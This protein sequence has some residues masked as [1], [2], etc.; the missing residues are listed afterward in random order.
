MTHIKRWGLFFL[1]SGLLGLFLYFRLYRYLSFENLK[2]HRMILINWAHQHFFQAIS[3]FMAIYTLTVAISVPGAAFLT[4]VAGFLFGPLAGTIA[5]IL[6]ATLGAF[7]IFLAVDLALREWVIQKTAKWNRSMENGF[8][9]NAFSYLLFLRLVP[10]FPFWLVNII[11]ALLGVSKYTFVSAT[12]LGIIPGAF[13]YVMMG[14]GLGH[15]LDLRDPLKFSSQKNN[16][17]Y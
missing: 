14:N 16:I 7:I 13:V 6:S 17:T 5:V 10:L 3:S 2:L 9:D 1:L 11:P 4:L 8:Q 15:V 12:I